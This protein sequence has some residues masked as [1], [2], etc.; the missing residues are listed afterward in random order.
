[1]NW[2][3]LLIQ[4][5]LILGFVPVILVLLVIG[6]L[7]FFN[8]QGIRSGM[9]EVGKAASVADASM[10]M[11][12][13][14][15]NDRLLLMEILTAG[16]KPEL[17]TM[18]AER[19][20]FDA[21]FDGYAQAI[22]NGGETEMGYISKVEDKA[23]AAIVDDV[24]TAHD[25]EFSPQMM[26]V[27]KTM[28]QSFSAAVTREESMDTMEKSYDELF[29]Y[30]TDF[31]EKG[32]EVVEAA[33]KSGG[34]IQ[35]L[36]EKEMKWSHTAMEIQLA[37]AN[38]RLLMEEFA[39]AETQAEWDELTK[40]Y[41]NDIELVS[42]WLAGLL[43][44]ARNTP[45]IGNIS[46]VTDNE[47]KSLA[48][49]GQAALEKSF[50]PNSETMRDAQIK[51]V[52]LAIKLDELDTSIDNLGIVLTDKVAQ[53]ETGAKKIIYDAN[54]AANATAAA[55]TIQNIIGIVVGTF[56][57]IFIAIF[58]ARAIAT[59]IANIA[60][61]IQRVAREKDLT[62]A[63]PVLSGDE[64]GAMA[65]EFNSMLNELRAAF[66]EVTKSAAQ[67]AEGSQEVAKR[68]A[69]N[70]ERA[71]IE[72]ERS[73]KAAA[74][75]AEMRDTAGQVNKSSE[76]QK[77]AADKSSLT[78]HELLDA[79]KQVSDAAEGQMAE[80]RNATE[81][82]GEMGVTGAK[83][84]EVAGEQ[85][86]VVT[87]VADSIDAIAKAVDDMNK[88]VER[89]TE[90][91][92]ASLAA[93]EEGS[94]SVAA[95]VVGMKAISESS[96]QISEII[97]VIT[98]IA[99]QTNLLALNAAIEAA[100][101]G[102]HGKGFA[103][104]ADE[105]GKLAQRSSEAAKEITQLIKDSTAKVTEGTLLTDSSRQALGKIDESGK[106]NMEAINEISGVSAMLAERSKQVQELMAGLNE[107]AQNIAKM[108]F[109]QGPRREAAEAALKSLQEQS[110]A[111]SGLVLK[112]N[113]DAETIN[114]EMQGIVSRTEGMT[115]MTGEQ[116]QR[117]AAVT[118]LSGESSAAAQ[119]TAEGAGVVVNITGD[120][121]AQSQAL[122]AQV[123][124]FKVE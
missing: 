32:D 70:R 97:G 16:D 26:E 68:A 90:H 82:V 28:L 112:T 107:L 74:I 20:E 120:L 7:G 17:D 88:A 11:S 110:A 43:N 37:L 94:N 75:I 4:R 53:I 78:I 96:E 45:I 118:E 69:A 62:L 54:T 39:M 33:I 8:I 25:A 92:T 22:L 72:V 81:R 52:G 44:G 101:A 56:L 50:I 1:M 95:T 67:V 91:G 123:E 19:Q 9:E 47:L 84:A 36:E 21:M 55:A 12:L 48:R 66:T 60:A 24:A 34:T 85:G 64:V 46:K 86:V 77:E 29:K 89:A 115:A 79:M 42:A 10:E 13:A 5:K 106:V 14:L 49:K 109:E 71:G 38:A 3:N 117:S 122:T 2:K 73:A 57:A 63:V 76:G 119:A 80:V 41:N 93:A 18:W 87:K 51:Y 40:A 105:V 65:R 99:E 121:L 103:V 116:A 83:V 30:M 6:F 31:E 100:R 108:A 61:I 59:P 114:Q 23:L 98:D 15:V 102:A 27:Y 111:I 58:I 113:K 35:A 124:Q 104:V